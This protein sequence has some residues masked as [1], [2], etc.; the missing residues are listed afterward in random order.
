MATALTMSK[1]VKPKTARR[2]RQKRLRKVAL[3]R[4]TL[5][6]SGAGATGGVALFVADAWVEIDIENINC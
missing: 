6:A 4:R 1:K 5:S 2:L 3:G